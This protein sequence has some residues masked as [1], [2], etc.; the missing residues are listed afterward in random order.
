[1][2]GR[3]GAF[4][5]DTILNKSGWAIFSI[6]EEVPFRKE[7]ATPLQDAA[8]QSWRQRISRSVERSVAMASAAAEAAAS[9]VV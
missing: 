7:K 2:D 3:S 5:T 6:P 1:M 4:K 8:Y 9:V